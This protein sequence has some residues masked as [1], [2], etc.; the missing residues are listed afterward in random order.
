[1]M[2]RLLL[3]WYCRLPLLMPHRSAIRFAETAAVPCSLNISSAAC[4]IRSCVVR[5]PMVLISSGLLRGR[6]VPLGSD[7]RRSVTASECGQLL[8]EGR[9]LFT[10][11]RRLL[12]PR[13][14][15]RTV[16]PGAQP[17]QLRHETAEAAPAALVCL[18][19]TL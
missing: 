14:A 9:P 5:V 13:E 7:S 8:R 3:K 11:Q 16:G 18:P 12:Q 17:L 1:M 19:V 6:A 2:S 10:R 4:R 15:L